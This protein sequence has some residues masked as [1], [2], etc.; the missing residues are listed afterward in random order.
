MGFTLL[1]WSTGGGDEVQQKDSNAERPFAHLNQLEDSK[2][3]LSN[4]D[5]AGMYILT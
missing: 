5:L 2:S 4:A 3:S 1:F